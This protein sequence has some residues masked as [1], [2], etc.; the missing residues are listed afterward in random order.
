MKAVINDS[1]AKINLSEQREAISLNSEKLAEQ[2][3]RKRNILLAQTDWT[4]LDDS[5]LS[6]EK[7]EAY[8]VYRQTLRDITAQEGFPSSVQFPS[9]I[10]E[11]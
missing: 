1:G 2:I 5:P 10:V 11:V 6:E 3:R 9:L 4:Q 7:K 8:R